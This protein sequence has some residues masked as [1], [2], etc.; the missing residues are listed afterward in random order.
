MIGDVKVSAP[1]IQAVKKAQARE[2]EQ[3][4]KQKKASAQAAKQK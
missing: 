4:K 2:K 1:G 3:K